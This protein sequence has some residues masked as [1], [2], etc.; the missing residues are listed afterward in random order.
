MPTGSQVRIGV[1][2]AALAAAISTAAYERPVSLYSVR[3]AYFL[4]QRKDEKT[5]AFLSQYVRRLPVPKTGPHVA[6]IELRTP[7]EQVVL[8]ARQAPDGYSS[9][10]AAEEYRAQPDAILVRVLIY[11]TPTY[12]AHSPIG[13]V[14]LGPVELRPENF[15]REFS[16]SL[17]QGDEISAKRVRGRAIYSSSAFGFPG[18]VGAE[19]LLEFDAER[20]DSAPV[21][22]AVLTPNGQ[23]VESE[24]DLSKLR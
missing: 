10:Q 11:L 1:L 23:R 12:P 19:V 18:L 15:W 17:V 21:R 22:V 9:Q 20:V 24:F 16:I 4:G 6:E 2:A 7:Y 3:E 5:A 13:V 14:Q 8:R